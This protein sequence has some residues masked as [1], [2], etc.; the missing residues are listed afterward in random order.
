MTPYDREVFECICRGMYMCHMTEMG[1]RQSKQTA[2]GAKSLLDNERFLYAEFGQTQLSCSQGEYLIIIHLITATGDV[3]QAMFLT[4]DGRVVSGRVEQ[5]CKPPQELSCSGVLSIDIGTRRFAIHTPVMVISS[6]PMS[7]WGSVKDESS[8]V[9]TEFLWA[10]VYAGVGVC[11]SGTLAL[12]PFSDVTK[13]EM[14]LLSAHSGKTVM[15]FLY[16]IDP[17]NAHKI[18]HFFSIPGV[19][20][21]ESEN[22]LY[23]GYS[24]DAVIIATPRKKEGAGKSYMDFTSFLDEKAI[25]KIDDAEKLEREHDKHGD[26]S[27]SEDEEAEDEQEKGD[28]DEFMTGKMALI[29]IEAVRLINGGVFGIEPKPYSHC[30][31][32]ILGTGQSID[33][34]VALS[35]S[36][37]G[38]LFENAADDL[39]QPF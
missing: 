12:V 22:G 3:T 39:P 7:E 9:I 11:P 28:A 29:K 1:H 6:S 18:H 23:I 27:D 31:E 36:Y 5:P 13:R 24:G 35:I 37:R 2:K 30:N 14:G 26:K 16:S 4:K 19:L 33:A 32:V 17:A 21:E 8:W 10:D 38:A 34:R 20:K 25:R 15:S